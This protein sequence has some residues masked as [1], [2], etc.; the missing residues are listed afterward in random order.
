MTHLSSLDNHAITLC[1]HQDDHFSV[2][3]GNVGQF[4]GSQVTVREKSCQEKLFIVNIMFGTTPV[5]ISILL[6]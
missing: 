5:F 2:K 3:P 4:D 6:A 1:S